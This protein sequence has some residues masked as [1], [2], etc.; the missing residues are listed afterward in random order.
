VHSKYDRQCTF[1]H[2]IEVHSLNRLKPNDPLMGCAVRDLNR[3][4]FLT[5]P[6]GVANMCRIWKG[7]V[8]RCILDSYG[9]ACGRSRKC[10]GCFLVW[11]FLPL[12]PAIPRNCLILEHSTLL[13][14]VHTGAECRLN[15]AE[16]QQWTMKPALIDRLKGFQ[17]RTVKQTY[18]SNQHT[19]T[20]DSHENLHLQLQ[21]GSQ[22]CLM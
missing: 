15:K 2:Y 16:Y 1:K 12:L 18:R 14:I 11:E 9:F 19:K 6:F 10:Q 3:P 4:H 8:C 7:F 21:K 22:V 5:S 17:W 13:F 20:G